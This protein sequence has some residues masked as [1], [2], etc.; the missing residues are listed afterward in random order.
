MTLTWLLLSFQYRVQ[1]GHFFLTFFW[2]REGT[3]DGG[4]RYRMRVFHTD[5]MLGSLRRGRVQALYLQCETG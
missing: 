4:S 3:E 5:V 2:T 1:R